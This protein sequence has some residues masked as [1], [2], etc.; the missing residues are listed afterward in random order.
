M[1]KT[2]KQAA[3]KDHQKKKAVLS[4]RSRRPLLRTQEYI[5]LPK[6]ME[7]ALRS[8]FISKEQAAI[9]RD[10]R[11]GGKSFAE[12]AQ[13]HLGHLHPSARR[14]DFQALGLRTAYALA[15]LEGKQKTRS[16][17]PT[18]PKPKKGSSL[19]DK[20]LEKSDMPQE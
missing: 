11:Q 1:T 7:E 15:D 9:A 20:T 12:S 17:K 6:T 8:K 13:K 18:E 19:L 10:V 4:K 14:A 16:H 5:A 2:S 3:K